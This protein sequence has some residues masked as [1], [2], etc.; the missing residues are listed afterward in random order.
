[1]N[2][3]FPTP[4]M[5]LLQN[6]TI[7]ESLGPVQ[8]LMMLELMVSDLIAIALQLYSKEGRWPILSTIELGEP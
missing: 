6:V 3:F 2:N 1:M 8:V 7:Q 4:F 5:I